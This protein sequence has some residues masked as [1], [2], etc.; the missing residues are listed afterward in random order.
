MIDIDNLTD[1][2]LAALANRIKARLTIP[3]ETITVRVPISAIE[4][5]GIEANTRG[6]TPSDVYREAIALY[7]ANVLDKR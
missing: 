2:E 3:M 6:V 7:I 5:I 4:R 1:S